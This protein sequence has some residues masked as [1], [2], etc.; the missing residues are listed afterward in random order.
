[1]R[2]SH[3][4]MDRDIR[5]LA[6]FIVAKHRSGAVDDVEM[7]FRAAFARFENWTE[8]EAEVS[9]GSAESKINGGGGFAVENPLSG[10]VADFLTAPPGEM[11]DF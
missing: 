7:R 6:E 5:G 8:N 2:S 4:A 10:G 9:M 1:M 11:P 3:D